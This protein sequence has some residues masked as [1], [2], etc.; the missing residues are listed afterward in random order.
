M[1]LTAWC[2]A[3][4]SP[5][6]GDRLLREPDREASALAQGGVVLG[7][8]H[9]PVPLLWDAVTAG[10]IRLKRHGRN[11]R[12][13]GTGPIMRSAFGRQIA[14][15]CNKATATLQFCREATT[16]VRFRRLTSSRTGTIFPE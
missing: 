10:G 3:R 1:R 11:P 9:Y 4:L 7:P 8:I 12:T 5:P 6:G 2:R 14:H 13:G 15:S 16:T